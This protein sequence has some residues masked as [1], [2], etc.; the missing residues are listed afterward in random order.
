MDCADN[1]KKISGPDSCQVKPHSKPWMVNL[2]KGKDSRH[3]CGGVL[4]GTKVVLTA[5]H[6]ICK[7]T[8]PYFNVT[9]SGKECQLWKELTVTVGDHDLKDGNLSNTMTEKQV[10]KIEYAEPHRKYDGK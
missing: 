4:I 9:V 8:Y 5:A 1:Y 3:Y 6:C 7:Y 10:S 2:S